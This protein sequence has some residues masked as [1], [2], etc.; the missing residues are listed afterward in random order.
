MSKIRC[1]KC[2]KKAVVR[3]RDYRISLCE[4]CYV[5]FYEQLVERSI[6]KFNVIRNG[7]RI[8]AAVSG[9]KDSVSMVS[10]LST[11]SKKMGFEL[12]ILHIDLG[13]KNY[14]KNLERIV[15]VVSEIL[16]LNLNVVRIKDFGFTLD[17]IEMKKKC[18]ACGTVK[19]YL[20]NKTARDL[21][22]NVVST[23]HTSEDLIEFFFKN[24]LSGNFDL[25]LKLVPRIEGFDKKMVTKIRPL[26]DRTEKENMLYVICKKLPFSTEVCPYA[27]SRD[28]KEIIYYIEYKKPGFKR[29]FIT[30]LSKFMKPEFRGE[31]NYCEKCGEITTGKICSFC[32]LVLK[33]SKK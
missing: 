31:Y 29:M 26:F 6:R 17:D 15:K 18:S 27:P 13:I 28:W 1:K 24:T 16:E 33:Y 12:E 21:K 5:S 32:K 30:N 11:L 22:F 23:G 8:L 3:L 2:G 7:D 10:V 19:R 14:S 4:N 25:N 9:G 20:M